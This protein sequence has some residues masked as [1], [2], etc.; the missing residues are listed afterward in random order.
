[1]HTLQ[2]GDAIFDL[3]RHDML[4]DSRISSGCARGEAF[5]S[6]NSVVRTFHAAYPQLTSGDGVCSATVTLR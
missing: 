6:L 2:V 5:I 4:Y 3:G 1:M